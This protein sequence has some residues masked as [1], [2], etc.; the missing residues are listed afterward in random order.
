MKNSC[1]IAINIADI[2]K[3]QIKELQYRSVKNFSKKKR[4]RSFWLKKKTQ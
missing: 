1:D 3:S 2:S 4:V